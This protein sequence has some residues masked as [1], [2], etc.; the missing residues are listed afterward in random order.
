MKKGS[1]SESTVIVGPSKSVRAPQLR[2]RPRPCPISGV[3]AKIIFIGF[4][5]EYSPPYL[6]IKYLSDKY[7]SKNL[8]KEICNCV[9]SL[10]IRPS[11]Q[12][13]CNAWKTSRKTAEHI[14]LCSKAFSIT[15]VKRWTW[16]IVECF[17]L[18]PNWCDG[19]NLFASIM[20][21]SRLI[22]SFSKSFDNTGS[23]EIGRYEDI[24]F[25]GLIGLAIFFAIF[26]NIITYL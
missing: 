26:H 9:F 5:S 16:S 18:N 4:K 23:S 25:G 19:I 2:I 24:S 3:C 14:F 13:L 12:T 15:S 8:Q 11:C 1:G 10:C 22:I 7:D 17:S 6:T 20:G 21:F